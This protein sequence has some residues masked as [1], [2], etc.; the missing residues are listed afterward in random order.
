[1]NV[2]S[3]SLG[4]TLFDQ[5]FGGHN[6]IFSLGRASGLERKFLAVVRGPEFSQGG[7]APGPPLASALERAGDGAD[8][9]GL[10]YQS[11]SDCTRPKVVMGWMREGV[12]P[13][14]LGCPGVSPPEIF[15]ICECPY[16]HF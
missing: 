16:V 5:Q 9:D 14:R 12:A 7:Q 13:S 2:R 8:F 10:Y 11:R 3:S 1:M 15:L 4:A 6:Y